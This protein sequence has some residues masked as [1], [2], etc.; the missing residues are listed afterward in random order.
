MVFIPGRQHKLGLRLPA[1][2]ASRLLDWSATG[3]VLD[4]LVCTQQDLAAAVWCNAHDASLND[5]LLA[6][7]NAY[8]WAVA[9]QRTRSA[10]ASGFTFFTIFV[11]SSKGF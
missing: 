5:L 1:P 6:K 2:N 7:R 11:I 10:G 3:V 9:M 4:S 8:N